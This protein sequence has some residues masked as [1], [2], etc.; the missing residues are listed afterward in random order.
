LER[1]SDDFYSM[2]EAAEIMAHKLP[3]ALNSLERY[4]DFYH[5]ISEDYNSM[6]IT[7]EDY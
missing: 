7:S 6:K 1:I 5:Q 4:E 3:I 2:A